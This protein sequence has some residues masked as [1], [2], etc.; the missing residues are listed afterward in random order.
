M[1]GSVC[2]FLELASFDLFSF[3]QFDACCFS[4]MIVAY[5]NLD[6]FVTHMEAICSRV[7]SSFEIV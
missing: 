4:S 3:S 5:H 1:K 6:I 7:D 2:H